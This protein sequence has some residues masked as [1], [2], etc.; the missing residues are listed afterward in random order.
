VGRLE[1]RLALVTGA[2][3]GIGR[4]IAL[5]FASEG[6]KIGLSD[7]DEKTLAETVEAARALGAEVHAAPGDVGTSADCTRIVA[8]LAGALGGLD[9]LANVAA[10]AQTGIAIAE[11]DDELYERTMNVCM[12]SVFWMMRAAYPYLKSSD[13]GSVIN[14]GSGAGTAGM[15]HNAPY[16]AAKEAIR[17]FSRSAAREWGRDGIRVNIICPSAVSPGFQGWLDENPGL[18]DSMLATIPLARFGDCDADIAPVVVFLA[19]DESRYLTAVTVPV[20]G[21]S[22]SER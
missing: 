3:R 20:D 9:I 10:W 15:S 18:A 7:I 4:A 14:F 12:S 11:T 2:G 13:H 22:G 6:A 21:G 5:A 1:G 8:E 16:A 17:G 19:S